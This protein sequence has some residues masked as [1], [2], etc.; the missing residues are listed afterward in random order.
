VNGPAE[1]SGPRHAQRTRTRAASLAVLAGALVAGHLVGWWGVVPVVS[2]IQGPMLPWVLGRGLGVAAYLSLVTVTLLGL[3][4]RHPWH[5]R[6]PWPRP[7]AAL[8]WHAATAAA[9]LVLTAGH[10]TSLA[11]DRFAGVGWRGVFVPGAATYRPV[12]VALGTLGLYAGLL[13]GVTAALAGVLTRRAWLPLHALAGVCFVLVWTHGVLAGSDVHAL[14]GLYVATGVLVLG[15]AVTRRL[16][17]SPLA[18]VRAD[19]PRP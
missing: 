1:G 17:P 2:V 12:P 16:A 5:G 14:R 13:V 10:L 8:R 19:R 4:L 18:P 15:L 9:T 3:W 6:Y 7:A 11:L